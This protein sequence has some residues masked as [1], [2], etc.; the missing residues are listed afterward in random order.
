MCLLAEAVQ[1]YGMEA[2]ILDQTATGH[3]SGSRGSRGLG[4]GPILG[5]MFRKGCFWLDEAGNLSSYSSF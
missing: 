2:R 4:P 3:E 1:E 5:W